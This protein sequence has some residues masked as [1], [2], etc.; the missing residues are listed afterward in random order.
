MVNAH[1]VCMIIA[2]VCFGLEGIGVSTPPLNKT[3]LGFC[4]VTLAFII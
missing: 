1:L 4:F 2:C 3:A